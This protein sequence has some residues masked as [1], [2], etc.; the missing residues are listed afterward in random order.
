M[1]KRIHPATGVLVIAIVLVL[2][3]MM[4]RQR[5]ETVDP[6]PV[7][8]VMNVPQGPPLDE[9]T[10]GISWMPEPGTDSIRVTRL[11]ASPPPSRLSLLGVKPGDRLVEVNGKTDV[12]GLLNTAL[13][14]LQNKGIPF[15]LTIARG[16]QRVKLEA[17]QL[18]A[19]LKEWDFSARPIA[20][21]DKEGAD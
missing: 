10:L 20:R 6:T 3:M 14:D 15:T 4:Y 19:A 17:K 2:V 9:P 21:K 1:K 7:P 13:N 5:L 16:S 11:L 18:P 12:Q 8:I